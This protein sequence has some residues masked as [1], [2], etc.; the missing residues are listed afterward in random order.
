MSSPWPEYYDR[1]IDTRHETA[2][3]RRSGRPA[4][5]LRGVPKS[6]DRHPVAAQ[7]TEARQ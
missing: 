5:E 3:A 4:T 6:R 7:T 2:I 1:T